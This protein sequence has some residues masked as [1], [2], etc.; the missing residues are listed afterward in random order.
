MLLLQLAAYLENDVS[1]P[2]QAKDPLKRWYIYICVCVVCCIE[3][4]VKV[5]ISYQ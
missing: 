4:T 2:Q 3:T 5:K 1:P